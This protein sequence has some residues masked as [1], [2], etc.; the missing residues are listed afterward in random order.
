MYIQPYILTLVIAF[1]SKA[2]LTHIV[3]RSS[4]SVFPLRLP[5]SDNPIP[6]TIVQRNLPNL[7]AAGLFGICTRF[8]FNVPKRFNLIPLL[9]DQHTPYYIYTI[10]R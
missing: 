7:T 5:G 9:N 3:G 4:D 6:V 2:Y 10:F 1:S 8:P